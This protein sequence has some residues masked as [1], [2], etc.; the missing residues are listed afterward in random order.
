MFIYINIFINAAAISLGAIRSISSKAACSG[1]FSVFM[2]EAI[3]D[4]SQGIYID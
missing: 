1:H 4:L 2:L 3:A